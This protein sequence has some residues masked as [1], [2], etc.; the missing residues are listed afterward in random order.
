VS[1]T[2]SIPQP[3]AGGA[4]QAP[5]A[6]LRWVTVTFVVI[7][8]LNIGLSLRF[9]PIRGDL[10][11]VGG[12]AERDYRPGVPQAAARIAPNTVDLA[13]AD[14]VVL[15]D[16]FSNKLLWQGEL[17]A[18]TGQRT[19]TFQYGQVGCISNFLRWLHG[20]QLKPGAQVIIESSE[21]SFIA[22]Y[23]R[24][25]ECPKFTPVPVHRHLET[26]EK[27]W[28][29]PD[30]SLDIVY[31]GRVLLNSMR[32]DKQD[33]Y[34]AGETVNV[35]LKRDDRF[36]NHR[37]DRL[38][39]HIDDE[40]K[41]DWTAPQLANALAGLAAEKAAFAASGQKLSMLVMPDK[42][43]VYRDEI[44]APR[45]RFS[46]ATREL[47]EAG[48]FGMDTMACFRTLA[49]AQP[50]FY[51]PDDTHLGPEGFRRVAASLAQGQQCVAPAA[52]ASPASA[53]ASGT[54]N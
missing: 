31:Q 10:A 33:V 27:P 42:S 43:S 29:D 1:T 26:G 17:E 23:N 4:H 39:Y 25:A 13:D 54:L 51:L 2:T 18:L 40:G 46:S 22:R 16:S 44:V 32:L 15:G 14:V 8:A 11:R 47:H 37:S 9:G 30:L 5:A 28:L 12:F 19:L 45:T 50:D 21:R 52:T 38:L 34:R 35:A 53:P 6:F 3:E 7:A 48:L 20:M 24:M 49:A 41:N 36:T